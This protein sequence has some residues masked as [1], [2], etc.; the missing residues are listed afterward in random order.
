MPSS[1]PP[2]FSI[3]VTVLVR[4]T[5]LYAQLNSG[6]LITATDVPLQLHYIRGI[7]VVQSTA[8]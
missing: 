1:S 5:D 7:S 4:I 6:T 2:L 8:G 3:G